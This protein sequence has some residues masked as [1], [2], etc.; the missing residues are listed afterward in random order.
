MNGW[1]ERWFAWH[2]VATQDRALRWLCVIERCRLGNR[3]LYRDP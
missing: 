2:P 1:W 3:W